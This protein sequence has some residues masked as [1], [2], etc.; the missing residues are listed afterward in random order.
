MIAK[1]SNNKEKKQDPSINK[2]AVMT[3]FFSNKINEK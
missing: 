2:S 1:I 3:S